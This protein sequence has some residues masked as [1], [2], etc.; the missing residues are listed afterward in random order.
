MTLSKDIISI[1]KLAI[2]IKEK[3][4]LKQSVEYIYKIL[5]DNIT[6]KNLN[7]GFSIKLKDKIISE[8]VFNCILNLNKF[9]SIKNIKYSYISNIVLINKEEKYALYDFALKNNLVYNIVSYEENESVSMP[10]KCL[11]FENNA[12]VNFDRSKHLGLYMYTTKSMRASEKLSE[13]LN[14]KIY[15]KEILTN[16]VINNLA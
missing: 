5:S 6:I 14:L 16:K 11:K 12:I 13:E 15:Y 7:S 10:F 3:L 9:L 2:N 8:E 1:E 4:E